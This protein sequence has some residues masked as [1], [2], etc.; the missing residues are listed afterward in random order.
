MKFTNEL[1]QRT[2][3][4]APNIISTNTPTSE[5]ALSS[6]EGA[7]AQN[8]NISTSEGGDSANITYKTSSSLESDGSVAQVTYSGWISIWPK[9]Y[10]QIVILGLLLM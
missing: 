6:S 1:D 2:S 4:P 5:G 9:R 3:P 8:R 10:L 7:K